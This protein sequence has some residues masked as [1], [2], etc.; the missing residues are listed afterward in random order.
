VSRFDLDEKLAKAKEALNQ[1][2]FARAIALLEKLVTE[3][4]SIPL[5]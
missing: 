5:F 4:P 2:D 3:D 1:A